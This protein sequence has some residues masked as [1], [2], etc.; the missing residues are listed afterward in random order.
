MTQ[1]FTFLEDVA[2]AD[3]AFEASGDSPSELILAA[4]QAVIELHLQWAPQ[5]TAEWSDVE[6]T[7]TAAPAPRSRGHR[8]RHHRYLRGQEDSR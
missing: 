1:R 4:T 6:F 2:L 8:R 7:K 3:A 5:G